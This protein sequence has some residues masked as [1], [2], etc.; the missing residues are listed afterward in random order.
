[1]LNI[2]VL[3]GP[4]PRLGVV[5][6]A[7][8]AAATMLTRSDTRRALAMLAA[9]ILAPVLLLDD[10]WHSAQ[11]AFVHRHP[12]ETVVAAVVALALLAAAAVLMRR[13][14]W[15]VAPLA[16]L[17]VPFRI[18]IDSGGLTNYLLVP[19]YFVIAASALGWLAPVLWRARGAGR[20]APPG[21]PAGAPRAVPPGTTA[22]ER[23]NGA[24]EGAPPRSAHGPTAVLLFERLLAAYIVLYALQALYAPNTAT[25]AAFPKALQNEVFFYVPFALLLARLRD[26]RWS[27]ELLIWCLSLTVA[28]AAVFSLIG[29]VE[30]AS[31]HLL[32]SSK[33]V[34]ANQLH[35]YFTVNS[36]F[37]DP[38]IFG[39]YLAMAMVLLAAVLLYD[40]RPRFQLG[41]IVAL[42]I[43]WG[44]LILTLSRSSVAALA[45]GLAVLA[46][47]RWRARPV[48]YLA[49][50]VA[51]VGGI[52][53]ATHPTKFGLNQG[54]NGASDGRANLV[55]G[56][57]HLFA[58]RPLIGWG[59]GSFSSEYTVKYPKSASAVSDSH[60][61]P[62]TI[63]AEQGIVGELLYIALVLAALFE[64]FRGARGDPFR[65]G[66]AA[67]FVALLLHTLLYADFLED[68]VTWTLLA[69]GGALA[70]SASATAA[71]RHREQRR[72]RRAPA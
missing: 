5:V 43:L 63:A 1:M 31:K 60:D 40:R 17:T 65:I 61:I 47:L 45:L 8:L 41:A 7:A 32:L 59:S 71:E 48:I 58:D 42:A 62:V 20:H 46:A 6:V 55:T 4:W 27:R 50:L 14:P 11:L 35:E 64:L 24:H 16:A 66:V 52:A 53:V 21:A 37:F 51:I 30:E 70:V 28:L 44:C 57:V 68:P 34:A 23:S 49:I 67:A 3:A 36:V 12:L 9:L 54:L 25:V 22:R 33:L 2:A 72:L 15:L 10:V 69:I 19:L 18:P 56:G 38:N 13:I 39:R 26:L 29:F